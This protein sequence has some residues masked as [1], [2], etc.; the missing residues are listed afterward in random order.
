MVYE[1]VKSIIIRQ[2]GLSQ[3]QISEDSRFIGDLDVDSLDAV[4]LVISIEKEFD[5]RIPDEMLHEE[6]T[7]GD[8]VEYLENK[9]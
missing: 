6:T 2:L 5:I 3:D 4:E 1:K 7:V 9:I 8:I